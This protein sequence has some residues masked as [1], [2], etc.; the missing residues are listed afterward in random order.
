MNRGGT[1]EVFA[2]SSSL[3]M[4]AFLFS[5]IRYSIFEYSLFEHRVIEFR[6]IKYRIIEYQTVKE[7]PMNTYELPKAYDFKDTERRIYEMWEK[8]GYFQPHND[9]NK[10]DFDPKRQAVCHRHP[11]AQRDRRTAHRPRHVRQ[12]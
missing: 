6:V 7:S 2:L 8:G 11:A 5:D 4:K 3:R 10:P 9:P 1:A 12:R